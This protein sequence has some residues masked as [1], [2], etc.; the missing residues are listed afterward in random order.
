MPFSHKLGLKCLAGLFTMLLV[1]RLGL[2]I[3]REWL[4]LLLAAAAALIAL[5]FAIGPLG[6]RDL[7]V[8]R[9]RRARLETAHTRLL[10]SN[11]ALRV[12]LK[13]L[14]GDDRYLERLI[15]EQLG[16]VRPDELVYRFAAPAPPDD[17]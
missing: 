6:M 2:Q 15:R 12:K 9:A 16:Y 13:R 4:T 8:L 7:M 11:A 5:D 10:E 14:R 17:R 1:R 3:R